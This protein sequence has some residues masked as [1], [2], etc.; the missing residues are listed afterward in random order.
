M[1]IEVY[2]A[3]KPEE[4]ALDGVKTL[5][6]TLPPN[7]IYLSHVDCLGHARMSPNKMGIHMTLLDGMIP[8]P[9][10]IRDL[11]RR[12]KKTITSVVPRGNYKLVPMVSSFKRELILVPNVED[13]KA[14]RKARTDLIE[15]LDITVEDEEYLP[16]VTLVR[17]DITADI[18]LIR[19]RIKELTVLFR[20]LTVYACLR[21]PS[22]HPISNTFRPGLPL[23]N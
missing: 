15:D 16:H 8:N 10:S 6:S 20:T 11:D 5:G 13:E 23:R 14:I 22:R 7:S 9:H 18:D 3:L 1:S 2:F 4:Q 19:R 17:F 12:M 21:G